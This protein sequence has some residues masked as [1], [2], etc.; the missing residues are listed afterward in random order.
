MDMS[1]IDM[2]F[3]VVVFL[4]L[5]YTATMMTLMLLE[6]RECGRSNM[7]RSEAPPISVLKPLKGLDDQLKSNLRS[8]F[9]L[10]YPRFELVFGVADYDDPAVDVVNELIEEYP[11]VDA[12]IV[13]DARKVGLNPKINNLINIYREAVYDTLVISDSNVWVRRGYLW[14]MAGRISDPSVGLVTSAIRGFGAVSLGAVLENLHLN[15]FIAGSV[16]AV[17]RVFGIPISIGKSMCFNRETIEKLGGF[18]ALS[19]YLAEDYLLGRKVEEMGLKAV[20]SP[21]WIDSVNE[22]WSL[23]KFASRH[24]RWALM[25]RYTN[26]GHY[27][28]EPLSNPVLFAVIYASV[29]RTLISLVVLGLTIYLKMLFDYVSAQTMDDRIR[30]RRLLLAPFKDL[31]VGLIWLVPL[32]N[33]TVSW[34]GNRFRIARE[35]RLLPTTQGIYDLSTLIERIGSFG[36]SL[37]EVLIRRL[38]RLAQSAVRA[39]LF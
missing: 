34:R 39:L 35:T 21:Y 14:D 25:R 10:A 7:R 1:I 28:L 27:I 24:Y 30:F 12:R 37:H 19:R 4:G 31:F 33:R 16:L 13:I 23:V 29:T 15:T 8:F 36:E 18:E 17:K 5:G 6:R 9:E 20:P 38:L 2:I 11:E 32:V 26:L 22:K 3:M